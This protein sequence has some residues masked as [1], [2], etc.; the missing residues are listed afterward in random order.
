MLKDPVTGKLPVNYRAEEL[1]QARLLPLRTRDDGEVLSQTSNTTN[2]TVNNTYQPA[3]PVNV[4]GRTRALAYDKRFNN[5]TNRVILSGG[6]S[7]GIFRS[8]DGGTT[9]TRVS[10]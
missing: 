6:V 4:G 10:P 5:T 2:T 9:W 8:T 1:A 7:G 3:G